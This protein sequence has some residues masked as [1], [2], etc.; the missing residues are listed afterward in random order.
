MHHEGIT[1]EDETLVVEQ[2]IPIKNI[3]NV[4]TGPIDVCQ[5]VQH[6]S[7]SIFNWVN[8]KIVTIIF[9]NTQF[10]TKSARKE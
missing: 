5:I 9:E 2:I 3:L 8:K 1:R 7:I 10:C 4:S 6:S